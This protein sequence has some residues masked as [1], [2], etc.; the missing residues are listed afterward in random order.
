MLSSSEL[1]ANGS[2]M[3]GTANAHSLKAGPLQTS[4]PI[5]TKSQVLRLAFAAPKV[6]MDIVLLPLLTRFNV[7]FIL[8]VTWDL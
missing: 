2:Q 6:A 1:L 4:I 3:V 5:S 8:S 7:F